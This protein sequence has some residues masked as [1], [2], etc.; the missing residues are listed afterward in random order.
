[1]RLRCWALFFLPLCLQKET[2][3]IYLFHP[4]PTC[5]IYLS[6]YEVYILQYSCMGRISITCLIV[7]LV[8]SLRILSEGFMFPLE[9]VLPNIFETDT[10]SYSRRWRTMS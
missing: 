3:S 6:M 5:T 2:T 7:E 9:L 8:V 1:M 10:P 4:F